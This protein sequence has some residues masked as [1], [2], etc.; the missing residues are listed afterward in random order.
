MNFV[1]IWTGVYIKIKSYL[2][3]RSCSLIVA[4]DDFGVFA[5]W[6]LYDPTCFIMHKLYGWGLVYV[7]ECDEMSKWRRRSNRRLP[8]LKSFKVLWKI[9]SSRMESK[10]FL[11]SPEKKMNYKEILWTVLKI[12]QHILGC[13][14]W[15]CCWTYVFSLRKRKK[16]ISEKV[17][18][19]IPQ[20][21]AYSLPQSL[22]PRMPKY[23]R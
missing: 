15:G 20:G 19:F 13:I 8:R 1:V 18:G 21:L 11:R 23:S 10:A 6:V 5:V 16:K 22:L 4:L 12:C 7:E 9:S 3:V 2:S 14:F 17:R